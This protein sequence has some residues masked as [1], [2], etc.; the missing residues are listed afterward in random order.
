MATGMWKGVGADASE[1]DFLGASHPQPPGHAAEISYCDHN[2]PCLIP[3]GIFGEE[4]LEAV[5]R[6][7][8]QSGRPV[9]GRVD[10][11]TGTPSS[12]LI[13]PPC[14]HR[15]AQV[16][17][18]LPRPGLY[19]PARRLLRPYVPGPVHVPGP[20]PCAGPASSPTRSLDG[21]PAPPCANAI[22]LQ[23]RAGWTR[24]GRWIN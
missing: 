13:T 8:R 11:A 20:L 5:M 17:P 1:R 22:W 6:F 3:D 24:P 7:Q 4:T 21:T 2:I 10:N 16:G 18:G 14:D 23:R 19:R 9:T 12:P 15:S